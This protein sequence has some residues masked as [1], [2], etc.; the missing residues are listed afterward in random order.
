MFKKSILPVPF[1]RASKVKYIVTNFDYIYP[2]QF[3]HNTFS[4]S[5]A[6]VLLNRS[7]FTFWPAGLRFFHRMELMEQFETYNTLLSYYRIALKCLHH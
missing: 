7:L 2:K 1:A 6:L 4:L 5:S 3:A